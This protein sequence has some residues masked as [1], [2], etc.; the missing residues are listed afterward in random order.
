MSTSELKCC[1]CVPSLCMY[2][3]SICD[4]G[5]DLMTIVSSPLKTPLTHSSCQSLL[6]PELVY[7]PVPE[8][9]TGTG[10]AGLCHCCHGCTVDCVRLMDIDGCAG[11]MLAG[12]NL[13]SKA[14]NGHKI[15][16]VVAMSAGVTVPSKVM[17]TVDISTTAGTPLKTSVSYLCIH[18]D[19]CCLLE[20]VHIRYA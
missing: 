10:S 3:D 18:I 9:G 20:R 1:S 2:S 6:I 16:Y 14:M 5:L 19:G 12:A 13:S 15:Q 7:I 17:E 11:A 4:L 8:T